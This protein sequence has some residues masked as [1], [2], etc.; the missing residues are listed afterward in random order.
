MALVP[1]DDRDGFIWWD[2]ALVPW[3]EAKLHVLTHGLHYASAVFEGERA[4][5]GN[6]FRL[7][8][9]TDRLINSARILGFEIP[10][11]AEQIDAACKETLRANN[12][13]EA[14]VRPIAWRG[15]EMLAVS[16]QHTKIHL[17]IAT[18][19]WPSYFTDKMAGISLGM[20]PWK[21]PSP[22]TAPTAAKATGLYMIG[23]LSKHKAE[24]EGHADALMLDWRGLVAESTGANI[25]FVRD[26]DIHTPTPDCFL[27]GITRR[28]VMALAKHRQ[29]KVIERAIRPEELAGFSECFLVGTAAEVTPVR[30]IEG[31]AFSPGQISET[32][33]KDYE[34]LVRKTPE[35]VA[36]IIG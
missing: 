17:A 33:M 15:S 7:R 1:F 14:Y 4:Y 10:Y 16:A 31:D 19:E 6:I 26:G 35:E 5:A 11:T 13:T 23:T 28:S 25:F 27:D 2:G 22:E 12:Q 21:R 3:R 34:A 9:H 20:A 29:I 18:W 32:L 24:A 30:R 8:A 36:R